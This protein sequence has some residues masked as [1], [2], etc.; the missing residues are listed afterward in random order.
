MMAMHENNKL[1]K[2]KSRN[3]T[4]EKPDCMFGPLTTGQNSFTCLNTHIHAC[5]QS[6]TPDTLTAGLF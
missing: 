4:A 1:L 6:L 3:F 5:T 2:R